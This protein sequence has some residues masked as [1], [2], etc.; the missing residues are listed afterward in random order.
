MCISEGGGGAI[1]SNDIY[2]IKINS[3]S[4]NQ[5]VYFRLSKMKM[6]QNDIKFKK[7]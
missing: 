3:Y 2:F 6:N 5:K 7:I 1:I 4:K